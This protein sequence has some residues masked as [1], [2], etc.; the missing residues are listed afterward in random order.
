MTE[1]LCLYAHMFVVTCAGA[2]AYLVTHARLN[3]DL[4]VGVGQDVLGDDVVEGLVLHGC[5]CVRL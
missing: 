1:Y 4:V 5:V 2:C 3:V